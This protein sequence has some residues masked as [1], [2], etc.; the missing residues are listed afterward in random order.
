MLSAAPGAAEQAGVPHRLYGVQDGAEPASAAMW[1][2]M[3]RAECEAAWAAGRVP[4]LVGGTGLYLRTLIDGIAP[5][6]DID[7]AVR[8][9]VR[10]LP[11]EA[12]WGALVEEDP[13]SATR[14]R[15]GDRQRISRAL[16]VVR[17]TGRPLGAWQAEREGALRGD[18]RGYV[19]EV[20][21]A[22]LVRRIERRF[23]SMLAGGALEE[24]ARLRDRG[25]APGLPVM[26]ALGVRPLL[27]HLAEAVSLTDAREA[28]VIETRQY[29]KR[30]RTWFRHQHPE[31]QKID[32]E[33]NII[34]EIA[35]D[36]KE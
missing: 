32:P 35:V 5:V 18:V 8:A 34:A 26:K 29:A 1:A 19:V 7:P 11:S 12:A 23:D 16:E 14:L 3:A 25:L 2:G 36:T 4:V 15:P 21:P 9:A 13:A 31:W 20:E 22:E 30:Q 33:S 10:A 27:A 17:S 28:A 24:V 6:P